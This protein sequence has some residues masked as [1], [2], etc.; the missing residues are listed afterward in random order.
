MRSHVCTDDA[1]H[2]RRPNSPTFSED[3]ED[4]HHEGIADSLMVS[5]SGECI[6]FLQSTFIY[7][8]ARFGVG[9]ALAHFGPKTTTCL[10]EIKN[11]FSSIGDIMM[12][13]SLRS[14]VSQVNTNRIK[15]YKVAKNPKFGLGRSRPPWC[16]RGLIF[17]DLR[18]L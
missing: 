14:R 3:M 15:P 4:V 2:C 9:T 12:H 13:S 1:G 8:K 10:G 16:V 6:D 18:G 7:E 11:I 5:G 17:I